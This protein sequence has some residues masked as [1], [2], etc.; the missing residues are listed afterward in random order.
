MLQLK[1]ITWSVWWNHI[2]KW[3]D[4]KIKKKEAIGIVWPNGC[5]KTSLIN[6]ING[7]NQISSGEIDFKWKNITS[8]SVEKRANL[9]IWR[10]FQS[11][12]IFKELTLYET[13]HLRL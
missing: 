8:M 12:G 7:F 4:L 9:W 11:C 1:N 3:I 2:L 6:S 13:Y 5:G 10:V